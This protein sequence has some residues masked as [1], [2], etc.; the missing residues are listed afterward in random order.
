LIAVAD[1]GCEDE[2]EVDE[3]REEIGTCSILELSL[4]IIP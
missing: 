1:L 4:F 2:D 3:G